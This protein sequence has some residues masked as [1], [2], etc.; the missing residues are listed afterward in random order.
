MPSRI[1]IVC[2]APRLSARMIE[3]FAIHTAVLV[4]LVVT[5]LWTER[6]GG[7][8][9][10]FAVP[11]YLGAI[12]LVAPASAA[13][14]IIEAILT[15]GVVWLLGEAAPRLGVWARVFGRERFLL[16]VA[17]SVPVRLLVEGLA[18]GGLQTVLGP[19]LP[20]G[21]GDGF[22][23]VGLVLVPLLANTFWKPGMVRGLLQVT[24]TTVMTVALLT[25]VV[26]PLL[27]LSF[28]SFFLSFEDIALAFLS[29]PKVYVILLCTALVA[30]WTAERYGFNAGGLLVPALLG[31]LVLEP[32]KLL[33]T[34][35][36]I[37]VLTA[38]YRVVT[39]LPGLRRL[40]LSG[41]RR[42]VA[43][44]LMA[45]V[46][47]LSF[48]WLGQ[49][50]EIPVATWNLYGF[51]YLLSSLVAVRCLDLRPMGR[52]LFPLG[53]NIGAGAG[54]GLFV[55]VALGWVLPPPEEE[56]DPGEEQGPAPLARSV[57]L[58]SGEVREDPAAAGGLAAVLRGLP[59][60]I[61]DPTATPARS[62]ISEPVLDGTGRDC[63]HLRSREA[64]EPGTQAW[65]CGGEGPLLVVLA[66]R[67]DPD[68][69]WIGA[70]LAHTG[71][72]P[73]VVLSHV[74]GG[75]APARARRVLQALHSRIPERPLLVVDT[76]SSPGSTRILARGPTGPA[77]RLPGRL[78]SV[79]L[80]FEDGAGL[81]Y[82]EDLD[83]GDGVLHLDVA[84]VETLLPAAPEAQ[85]DFYASSFRNASDVDPRARWV[86]TL[87]VQRALGADPGAPTPP[88][89]AWSASML[90][91]QART[92][93]EP[94]PGW[95]VQEDP[96]HRGFGAIFLRP[97]ARGEQVVV[98]PRA[99]DEDGAARVAVELLRD[100]DATSAW[101][102]RRGSRGLEPSL[103]DALQDEV[104]PLVVR[105]LVRREP[106]RIGTVLSI[107]RLSIAVPDPPVAALAESGE[108]LS[109]PP[110]ALQAIREVV[111]ARYP[112]WRR[113]TGRVLEPAT[114]AGFQP[115]RYAEAIS[116]RHAATLW[117]RE[118]VLAETEGTADREA[119]IRWYGLQG[120]PAYTQDEIDALG[121]DLRRPASNEAVLDAIHQ[122]FEAPTVHSVAAIVERGQ[123][124]LLTDALRVALVVRGTETVCVGQAGAPVPEAG[125][126]QPPP[127]GPGCWVRR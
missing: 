88:G 32:T 86:A 51:G 27:G 85:P 74:D 104:S 78:E 59:V 118:D 93:A 116:P 102:A 26:M 45:W 49:Q 72:A 48:A 9:A 103:D 126:V 33:T 43:M 124:L 46:L 125:D 52:V 64:A 81:P 66:A 40:E 96:Q 115:L 121:A 107:R 82:W 17:A 39:S 24:A 29:V 14:L 42:L 57:L 91:L 94:T 58:A 4:G 95:L 61:V 109:D 71:T 3:S 13:T 22:F 117:I 56:A 31:L 106:G 89:L 28:S 6:L 80:A 67:T 77:L 114:V 37:I 30:T 112:G 50:F 18:A 38:L 19:W 35:V 2:P 127:P 15:Y 90:G 20:D 123:P 60:A 69:A 53:L 87:G 47:K 54:V 12:A 11:G 44:Y 108:A 68:A 10:G 5:W 55:S 62:V 23:S 79:P 76:A 73:G 75:R 100:L 65:W 8:F 41:S 25:V 84:E 120:I 97:G 92:A 1:Q 34:I 98:A 105:E 83:P 101:W 111:S 99:A 7:V 122:H 113:V 119:L 63:L 36:E 16:F 70:W 21:A 110:P